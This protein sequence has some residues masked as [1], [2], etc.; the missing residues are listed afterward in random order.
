[1]GLVCHVVILV[2]MLC[3]VCVYDVVLVIMLCAVYVYVFVNE[4]LPDMFVSQA[5]VMLTV[6]VSLS[7]VGRGQA[8]VG[9]P[10]PPTLT[11]L[12]ASAMVSLVCAVLVRALV[13]MLVQP[14]TTT[15]PIVLVSLHAVCFDC[16][17]LV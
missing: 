10:L 11:L 9:V 8:M 14:T 4:S 15:F 3:V 6:W 7:L 12:L 1:M 13:G 5:G 17:L 2:I 16:A